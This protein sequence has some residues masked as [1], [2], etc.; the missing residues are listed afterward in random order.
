MYLVIVIYYF[1]NILSINDIDSILKPVREKY[2]GSGDKEY[3]LEDIYEGIRKTA[4][5]QT[6]TI[7][8][9]LMEKYDI[10]GSIFEDAGGEDKEILTNL[11]FIILLGL[12]VYI[13][14]LLMEKLV[15]GL[16]DTYDNKDK[17]R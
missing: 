4:E 8:K 9:D 11:S 12:D 2:L 17:S 16:N 13:K 10:A 5:L 1:K 14:K 3:T 7:K 15:D 6:D